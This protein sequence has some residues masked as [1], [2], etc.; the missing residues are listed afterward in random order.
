MRS[1]TTAFWKSKWPW[2]LIFTLLFILILVLINWITIAENETVQMKM[3][4][5]E[6]IQQN[7]LDSAKIIVKD[8]LDTLR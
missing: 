7:D 5:L 2:I 1:L 3:K 8:Y 4:V 6:S